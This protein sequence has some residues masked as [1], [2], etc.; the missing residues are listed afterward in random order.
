[1]GQTHSNKLSATDDD[2]KQTSSIPSSPT[3]QKKKSLHQLKQKLT[4]SELVALKYTFNQ[5]KTVSNHLEYVELKPFWYQHMN[6]PSPLEKAGI[7]LF[8][9]FS[10]LGSSYPHGPLSITSTA[11]TAPLLLSWDAF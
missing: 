1:M 6:L 5:L 2:N 10:Y 3:I 8:K 11:T 4:R 9:S 7:L